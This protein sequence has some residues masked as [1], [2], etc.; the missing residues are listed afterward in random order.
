VTYQRTPPSHLTGNKVHV[1][2]ASGYFRGDEY[3]DDL[4]LGSVSVHQQ[5]ITVATERRGF[6]AYDGILG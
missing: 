5:S 4:Q 1:T 3:L 2:Y 6:D